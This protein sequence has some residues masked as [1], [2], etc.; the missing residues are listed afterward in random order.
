M[1]NDINTNFAELGILRAGAVRNNELIIKLEAENLKLRELLNWCK[2]TVNN[3]HFRS[4]LTDKL[5]E[6]DS[7]SK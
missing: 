2:R 6:L 4:A 1:S 3:K 5:R 7:P